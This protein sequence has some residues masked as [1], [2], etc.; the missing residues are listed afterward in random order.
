MS[1][2]DRCDGGGDAEPGRGEEE[3][4]TDREAP[5]DGREPGEAES[6]RGVIAP[7]VL[8]EPAAVTGPSEGEDRGAVTRV[9]ATRTEAGRALDDV[10]LAN[11]RVS[12]S[13]FPFF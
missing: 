4:P 6:V 3:E 2:R 10:E 7:A 1:S 8:L 13:F 5:E 12:V 9:A 11:T